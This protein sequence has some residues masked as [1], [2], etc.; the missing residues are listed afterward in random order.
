MNSAAQLREKGLSL[1]Q[2]RFEIGLY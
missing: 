1:G 2:K